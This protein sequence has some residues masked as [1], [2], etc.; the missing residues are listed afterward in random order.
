MCERV[1]VPLHVWMCTCANVY[2]CRHVWMCTCADMCTYMR[3]CLH[4]CFCNLQSLL[5]FVYFSTKEL[6]RDG[7]NCFLSMKARS[8]YSS[9]RLFWI[10]VPVSNTWCWMSHCNQ[11][12]SCTIVAT[13]CSVANVP[14][15]PRQWLHYCCNTPRRVAD[16]VGLAATKTTVALLL[17]HLSHSGTIVAT[18]CSVAECPAATK[19]MVAT[20]LQHP[21]HLHRC[22]MSHCN[23]DNSCTIVAKSLS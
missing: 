11:D 10:G 15:Q 14:L 13:S 23:Q 3:I 1:H 6:R 20:L 17:Q 4:V 9:P 5:E 22:W 16:T 19:T 21:S 2:V 8:A 12:N 7:L 18:S